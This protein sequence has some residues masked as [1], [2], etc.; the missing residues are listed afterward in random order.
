MPTLSSL[1]SLRTHLGIPVTETGED[2]FLTQ[3][4]TQAEA[5]VRRYVR[6]TWA[7]PA[8]SYTQYLMGTNTDIIL[9]RERPVTAI[10]SVYLDK[11]AFYGE[12]ATAFAAN[13][14]LTEGTDYALIPEGALGSFSGRLQRL[15]SVWPGTIEYTYGNLARAMVFGK[16]PIK[17]VYTAGFSAAPDDVVLA[18]NLVAANLRAFR[19]GAP[20]SSESYD[21]YSV[22]FTRGRKSMD[23]ME[24]AYSI[25]AP[26]R[27][28][29]MGVS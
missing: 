18:V 3:I 9:L 20:L 14:L 4:L 29:T 15:N 24:P 27:S 8:A 16:G 11:A 25:L 26:Y 21:G 22:S 19:L 6:Q 23:P 1:S 5:M 17:V 13:T 10:T 7:V 12:A 28:L 2:T